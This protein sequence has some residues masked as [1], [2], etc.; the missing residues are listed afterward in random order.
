[1]VVFYTSILLIITSKILNRIII[2]RNNWI[3]LIVSFIFYF[4]AYIQRIKV[5]I[6]LDSEIGNYFLRQISLYG[7]SQFPF[8]V[9]AIFQ[10]EKLYSYLVLK[11][12]NLK[13]KNIYLSLI[14]LGMIIFHGFVETLFIA[15]FTGIV[16]ICCFNLLDKKD[17]INKFFQY[18]GKHSTNLWLVHMFI[19]MVFFKEYIYALK[20][21]ILIYLWLIV[22]C[23][24]FS[25]MINK[26][27]KIIITRLEKGEKCES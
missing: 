7:T 24:V 17:R 10:K 23:L 27:E 11:F 21:P 25:Y 12:E 16:F 14:I 22:I 19:Y 5:P 1:M 13:Y 26:I 20:Y 4:V 9:G 18:M 15:V 8:V 6:V 2:K 3:I